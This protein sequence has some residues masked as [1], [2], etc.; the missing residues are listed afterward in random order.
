MGDG[1]DATELCIVI[2]PLYKLIFFLL[3]W[4]HNPQS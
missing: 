2:G 3:F 4:F 1:D